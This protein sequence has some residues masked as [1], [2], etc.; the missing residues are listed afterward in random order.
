MFTICCIIKET[1]KFTCVFHTYNKQVVFLNN[2]KKWF[3]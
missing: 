1:Y 2:F 3:L